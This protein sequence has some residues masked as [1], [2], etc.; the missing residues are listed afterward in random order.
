L[1]EWDVFETAAPIQ[2]PARIKVDSSVATISIK[3]FPIGLHVMYL[4]F[5]DTPRTMGSARKTFNK[6]KP[7]AQRELFYG[8][9]L[10]G[11]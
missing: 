10:Y 4:Y 2:S 9:A 5:P 11:A 8:Q 1:F 6:Q 7:E 3:N